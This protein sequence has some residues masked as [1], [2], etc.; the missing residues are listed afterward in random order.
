MTTHASEEQLILYY[1]GEAAGRDGIDDHL[2]SCA[3]CRQEY[4]A[5]QVALNL[6]DSATVPDC[7]A[8]YGEQ[9]WERIRWRVPLQ[10]SGRRTP[11]SRRLKLVAAV[12]GLTVC[13]Y[14]TGRLTPSAPHAAPPALS[15]VEARHRVL[16]VAMS[17][18]LERA[19]IVLLE[20]RN[21]P[22]GVIDIS[23]ERGKADDLVATNRLL[24]ASAD[25]AG[26][27]EMTL[28]LDELERVLLE[29]A[30]SP[31]TLSAARTAEILFKMQVFDERMRQ[32]PERET[33]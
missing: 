23:Q 27:I 17:E 32:Q 19:G 21:A 6:M 11:L 8:P 26:D 30:R 33:L 1:Y 29:A 16:L 5:L 2:A 3:E 31:A 25:R 18:H 24:R 9:V 13:A 28:L 4:R 7:G 15:S 22:P 14:L 12:A 10:A 20:M